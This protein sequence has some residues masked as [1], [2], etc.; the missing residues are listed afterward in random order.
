MTDC[1]DAHLKKILKRAKVVAVVGVSMNPVRP[2]Y[3]VARYLG[4]KGYRVIP[5]NPG[6][7]GRMLFGETVR[8]G[9]S[10]IDLPVDMVDIF[11][12]SEAVPPIVDEA[13]EVFP[14]LQT[15]W[16]QIGVEHAE[17][18][19]RAEARGV[20]VIQNRCP[21][22]EYQRLFGELRMGGFATGI[23]SSKL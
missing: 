21:K 23:I 10:D 8:A 11:R 19:A 17:A 14:A 2:S 12:R 7:A 16:M 20:T 6:H 18:A 15:I 4:L 22:I 9:L 3:Y 1:S 13:L 5:V